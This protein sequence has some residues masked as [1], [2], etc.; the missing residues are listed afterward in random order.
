[1][2]NCMWRPQIPTFFPRVT[3]NNTHINSTI[4]TTTGNHGSHALHSPNHPLVIRNRLG[5]LRYQNIDDIN[6]HQ[7]EEDFFN[8]LEIP[9]I[10]SNL[11]HLPLHHSSSNPP[12]SS[13]TYTKS[14]REI[15]K[16]QQLIESIEGHKIV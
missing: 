2:K 15:K 16:P 6:F 12:Q 7:E 10:P 4:P 5:E 11:N 13:I 3:N 9:T 14:S 1:M 8:G